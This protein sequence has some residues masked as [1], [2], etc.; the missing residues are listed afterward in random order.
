MKIPCYRCGKELERPDATNADYIIATDTVVKEP[1][2]VLVALSHTP[3][4]RAKAI[5]GKLID[6]NEY[7][8]TEIPNTEAGKAIQGLV[9]V[10]AE[11]KDIDVQKTGIICPNC[12]RDT[13]KLI[14]GVHK[15]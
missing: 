10:V 13:D 8:R 15:K 14:W 2:A 6:D 1:R 5:A 9:K 4:T 3:S 11:V 7:Q 12:Y